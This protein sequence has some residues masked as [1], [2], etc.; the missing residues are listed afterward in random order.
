MVIII[1]AG[2]SGLTVAHNLL[3]ET[4]YQ[5]LEKEAVAGGLSTQFQSGEYWFD[6]GGHYFHFQDKPHV[7]TYLEQFCSFQ[8]FKRKSKTFLMNR[9][10][11]FPVQFNLSHLPGYTKKKIFEEMLA[12]LSSSG[13]SRN[14]S[15][16]PASLKDFLLHH[17]GTHLTDLFFEPFLSK[18]Y[19]TD[20]DDLAANMDKGSIP[21]PDRQRVM[22]GYSGKTFGSEGYNPVILYP[23]QALRNFIKNY[24]VP[25]KNQIRFNETV[26]EIDIKKKQV[27]TMAGSH[28]YDRLVTTMP[29]NYLLDMIKPAGTLPSSE[30][31]RHTSTL[32]VNV[33][34][35]QRRKRFHWVYLAEKKFPFYRAG[36][37]AGQPYTACYMERNMNPETVGPI[38]RDT[39]FQDISFTLKTLGV[40]AGSDEI[41]YFDA[42]MIPVS[43]VIFDHRWHSLV[44]SLLNQLKKFDIYSI[45]RFGTW[46]YSSMAN[47][48]KDALEFTQ[49][50]NCR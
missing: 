35:K 43:Y 39:L 30:G 12:L 28:H 25:V 34:L 26:L 10:I 38:D 27:K 6:Y 9:Y 5:V 44:P 31:L 47:D 45:G 13:G 3:E 33:V 40:I 7:Q 11:P 50:F 8:E 37:Y 16:T 32:L 21:V 49:A 42:R 23:K 48:I 29:L 36:L 17:F 2:V 20:I 24:S 15:F 19:A 18:Y 4:Q 22:L 1:G 41:L 46:N 14:S